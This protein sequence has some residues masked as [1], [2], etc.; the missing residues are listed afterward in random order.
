MLGASESYFGACAVSLGHADTAVALLATMPLFMGSIAQAFTGQLV[1][2]LGSRKRLVLLGALGQA[3][4]HVGLIAVAAFSLQSF[5]LLLGLIIVYFMSG[6]VIGPAWGAWMG[7]LTE[8]RDRERYFAT[9]STCVSISTLGAYLW[10]GYHL[11]NGAAAH[12]LSHAYAWLF[13]IGL[14][15]RLA[16]SLMIFHQPDLS[17]VVR[18]SMQRV[19][20]RTRSAVKGEGFRL[21]MLLSAFMLG[22][23]VSIPFYTAY[24]LKT[25]GLGY[26]GFAL[27]NSVQLIAKAA[28]FPF[29]HRIAAR[30]G[31]PRML[32]GS[33]A[34]A[35][36][37]AF[38]WGAD[39]GIAGLVVAQ[40]ISGIAWAGYEFASFQ[41]LLGS[42]TPKRRVEFL[43]MSAALGGMMQLSGALIGSFLLAR[44]HLSYREIFLISSILRAI[45]LVAFVPL[46]ITRPARSLTPARD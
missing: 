42:T 25:M 17:P 4:S 8:G 31:L 28:A 10:A 39:R 33:M 23:H 22:A 36:L 35:A 43:A 13:S 7:A 24:M 46:F 44:L 12:D 29:T 16:S 27:I 21:A 38:M 26:D 18:D 41:M 1:L 37:V 6:M 5:W 20:A 45:P 15:A 14:V 11:R 2:W 34:G 9:R 19:L 40:V 3:L 30:F 32:I